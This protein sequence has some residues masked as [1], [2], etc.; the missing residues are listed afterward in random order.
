MCN[1]CGRQI[2]IATHSPLVL[3]WADVANGAAVVRV[4]K[5]WGRSEV[6]QVSGETLKKVANLA[7]TRNVKN[8]HTVGSVAK[9]AFFMED[10]VILVEGQDDAAYL[11]RIL[12]DLG[13]P[14]T[15]NVYGWGSGGAGN[16]PLLAQLFLEM[17]FSHVGVILDDDSQASTISAVEKLEAMG[18]KVMVRQLPA[19]D[20]RYKKAVEPKPEVLGVLD[21]ENK[22]VRAELREGTTER[23]KE[24][25]DHVSPPLSA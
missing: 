11:P 13:L 5:S 24:I 10:G 7:D 4:Y 21:D 18:E 25:L 12:D 23:L 2:I 16:T 6:A 1:V 9:E 14:Q 19:P 20:I 15:E 17:G 22:H 3:D 8:P